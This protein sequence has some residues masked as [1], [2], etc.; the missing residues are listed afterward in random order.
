VRALFHPRDW[1]RATV[2]SY[3]QTHFLQPA[4]IGGCIAIAALNLSWQGHGI[5][6]AWPSVARFV[7]VALACYALTTVAEFLWLLLAHP[8]LSDFEPRVEEKPVAAPD[9]VDPLI[10]TLKEVPPDVLREGTLQLAEQMKSFEAGT[11]KEFVSTMLETR[12]LQDA[13]EAELD[14]VIAEDSGQLMQRHLSTWRTYR[15]QFYRPARAFRDE[16]R[17]RLGIRNTVNE[18]KIPALDQ[19]VLTGVNPISQ[20]ADYL[21]ALARRLK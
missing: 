7:L 11:D 8:P 15:E 12:P 21:V 20:A 5:L 3:R 14:Q 13:T 2:R 10:Q 18:P 16:L 6:R 19:A 4:K 1:R 9:A 17:R